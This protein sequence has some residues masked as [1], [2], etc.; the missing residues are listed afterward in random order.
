MLMRVVSFPDGRVVFH[1]STKEVT[2]RE[3]EEPELRIKV[4]NKKEVY[5]R[6]DRGSMVRDNFFGLSRH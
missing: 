3:N 2:Y 6:L 5:G 4:Y 1:Y